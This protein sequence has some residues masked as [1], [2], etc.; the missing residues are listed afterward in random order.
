MAQDQPTI[1]VFNEIGLNVSAV[2]NHEFD[3]GF[4]DLTDRVIGP[5][6]DRNAEWDYLGANVYEKAPR[7]PRCPSTACIRSAA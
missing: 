3:Q 6:G 7:P 4:A 5:A 2:G 1:D